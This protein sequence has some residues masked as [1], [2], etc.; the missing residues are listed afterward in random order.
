MH[1]Y[2]VLLPRVL[3]VGNFLEE[4]TQLEKHYA[5]SNLH[6]T[7]GFYRQGWG[8][9][10]EWPISPINVASAARRPRRLSTRGLV[11]SGA[12]L[13]ASQETHMWRTPTPPLCHG[14]VSR[15]SVSLTHFLPKSLFLSAALAKERPFAWRRRSERPPRRRSRA[16]AS[17][18]GWLGSCPASQRPTCACAGDL[19]ARLH[20]SSQRG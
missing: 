10:G 5:K 20:P 4:R 3:F 17:C 11:L 19:Q 1:T 14:A 6:C 13:R 9:I 18:S 7:L 12:L 15:A 8:D 2:S 16:R